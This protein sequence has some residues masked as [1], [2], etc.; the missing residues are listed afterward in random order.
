M[1]RRRSHRA[2]S[3]TSRRG[4]VLPIAQPR[5]RGATELMQRERAVELLAAPGSRCLPASSADVGVS[6]R[7][8]S[9]SRVRSPPK[10]SSKR[11]SSSRSPA[12][13]SPA[14]RRSRTS[15]DTAERLGAAA[16]SPHA[17]GRLAPRSRRHHERGERHHRA[18]P[19]RRATAPHARRRLDG[20]APRDRAEQP[21]VHVVP[22]ESG[23]DRRTA[24][25]AA[26]AESRRSG[27][28]QRSAVRG[29][30]A[31]PRRARRPAGRRAVRAARRHRPAPR[32]Q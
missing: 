32:R 3:P 16:R 29:A 18:E 30:R 2:C 31:S 15:R 9:S 19:S 5:F 23:D 10:R 22:L 21:A 1:A 17:D 11:S 12:R 4:I 24:G 8:H 27:R 26:R 28:R 6:P 7:A 25:R 14:S 13:S 20:P